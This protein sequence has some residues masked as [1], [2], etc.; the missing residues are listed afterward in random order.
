MALICAHL[1]L[2]STVSPC[3][4]SDSFKFSFKVPE[5][6]PTADNEKKPSRNSDFDPISIKLRFLSQMCFLNDLD[7][8][9]DFDKKN[10]KKKAGQVEPFLS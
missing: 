8:Q 10:C 5:I 7:S 6:Q 2:D 3:T 4:C 1:I 9:R